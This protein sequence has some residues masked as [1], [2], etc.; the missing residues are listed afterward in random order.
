MNP[1]I[2]CMWTEVVSWSIWTKLKRKFISSTVNCSWI[3]PWSFY[4]SIISMVACHLLGVWKSYISL[5]EIKRFA[6]NFCVFLSKTVVANLDPFGSIKNFSSSPNSHEWPVWLSNIFR[7][8]QSV[9]SMCGVIKN[10]WACDNDVFTVSTVANRFVWAFV[11]AFFI[12]RTWNIVHQ[13][14]F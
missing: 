14:W 1:Y 11:K 6:E 12:S 4:N 8:G 13:N 9:V 2:F 5:W 10:S 7:G 3:I